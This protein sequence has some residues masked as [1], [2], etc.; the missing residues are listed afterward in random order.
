MTCN[1]LKSVYPTDCLLQASSCLAYSLTLNM[2]TIC[3]SERSAD[4]HRTTRHYISEYRILH[5]HR[6][7]KLKIQ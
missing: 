5:T 2:G 1:H 6:Y 4:F 3:S 7:K